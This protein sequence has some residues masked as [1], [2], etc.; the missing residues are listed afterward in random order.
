MPTRTYYLGNDNLIYETLI[1]QDKIILPV[2][3]KIFEEDFFQTAQF[4]A[5][6][7]LVNS[8]Y[9]E[10]I[11]LTNENCPIDLSTLGLNTMVNV[12]G[13]TVGGRE[14]ILENTV[15]NDYNDVII[16]I[17]KE[18]TEFK[19]FFNDSG[20]NMEVTFVNTLQTLNSDEEGNYG[21]VIYTRISE[22]ELKIMFDDYNSG[23]IWKPTIYKLEA[24]V[25]NYTPVKQLPVSEI[26]NN[27]GL[28][29]I[30]LGF[31][32][33]LFTEIIK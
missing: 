12:Y 29:T 1:P 20:A 7:E 31:K 25:D 2:I 33:T 28:I 32:K 24:Y 14:T 3:T 26:N 6:N 16:N 11:I 4:N 21:G 18:T 5:V 23:G 9:N 27:N 19:V 15:Y 22:T 13:E 10:N 17:P 30:K 8:R